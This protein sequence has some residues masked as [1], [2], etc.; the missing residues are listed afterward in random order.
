[1]EQGEHPQTIGYSLTDSPAGLA[2]WMLDHDADSYSKIS[3][4]FLGGRPAGDLTCDRIV[5]N[6]TLYWLSGTAASSA[7]M[8]WEGARATATAAAAAAAGKE[9]PRPV[10]LPTAFTVFPEEIYPRRASWVERVYPNLVSFNAVGEGGHFAAWEVPEL[11]AA[12]LRA[13]FR[14]MR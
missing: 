12:E 4:A 13:G 2:A 1:M 9:P 11:F 10:S 6:L 3:R 8:Y 7:R 14:P 5:D